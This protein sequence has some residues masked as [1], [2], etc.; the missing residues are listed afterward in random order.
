MYFVSFLYKFSV[1]DLG[2]VHFTS[3]PFNWDEGLETRLI[4]CPVDSL[5]HLCNKIVIDRIT[6]FFQ[7]TA[8]F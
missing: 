5:L 8:M 4:F 3:R 7:P 6:S 1:L 2:L